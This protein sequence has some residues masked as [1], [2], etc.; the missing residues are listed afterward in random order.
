MQANETLHHLMTDCEITLMLQ[1]DIMKN[2]M[3]LPDMT[4]LEKHNHT[5]HTNLL[6][7][8]V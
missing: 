6:A 4:W 7:N 2:K 3:P 5:T 1:V 8:D